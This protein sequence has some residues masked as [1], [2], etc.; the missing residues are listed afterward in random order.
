MTRISLLTAALTLALVAL[1]TALTLGPPV[2]AGNSV[3]NDKIH[4][5]LG[6]GSIVLPAALFRPRW[7]WWLIPAAIVFGGVIEVLQM[8]VGR[9]AEMLDWIAD[10]AGIAFA[11]GTGYVAGAAFRRSKLTPLH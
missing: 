1:V 5:M 3:G 10:I 11:S 2:E 7:L 9:D 4:H 6:F 8:R